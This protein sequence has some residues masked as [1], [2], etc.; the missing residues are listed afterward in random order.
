M[1]LP[2][3]IFNLANTVYRRTTHTQI[4][5]YLKFVEQW[6]HEIFTIVKKNAHSQ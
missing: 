2:L 1:I 3:V 5:I 6:L 4:Y